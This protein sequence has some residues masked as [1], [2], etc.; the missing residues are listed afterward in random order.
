MTRLVHRRRVGPAA[1]EPGGPGATVG[2]IVRRLIA[3]LTSLGWLSV[4]GTI[5]LLVI[6]VW[7]NIVE[8]RPI[9]DNGEPTYG[10]VLRLAAA[11]PVA[12]PAAIEIGFPGVGLRN[13]RL[14]AGLVMLAVV[15]FLTPPVRYVLGLVLESL[16]AGSPGDDAVTILQ[17]LG[18][19]VG[20]LFAVALVIAW[21]ALLSGLDVAG[22]LPRAAVLAPLVAAVVVVV[23][24]ADVVAIA[25]AVDLAGLGVDPMVVLSIVAAIARAGASTAVAMA[26]LVGAWRGLLPRRA[27]WI[28]ALAGIALLTGLGTDVLQAVLHPLTTGGSTDVTLLVAGNLLEGGA[29]W[30]LLIVACALGLG[31]GSNDRFGAV[32]GGWRF[33]VRG[34]QRLVRPRTG[35]AR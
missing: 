1:T 2:P 7:P 11:L 28:G 26:L 19:V 25:P 8:G 33:I 34:G 16:P 31:R 23:G 6:A 3:P 27:W 24:A 22:A 10:V 13:R 12:L 9:G 14:Y 18:E 30:L 29:V 20:L 15:S 35:L 4:A 5:A 32:P 21:L 17:L